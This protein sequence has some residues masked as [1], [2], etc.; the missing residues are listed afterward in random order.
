MS[1]PNAIDFGRLAEAHKRLRAMPAPFEGGCFCGAFRYR[2]SKPPFWSSNCHCRA[3]QKLTG[4]SFSTA[5]TVKA[6]GFEVLSGEAFKFDRVAESEDV[7]TVTRCATCGVWVFAE[8]ASKPEYRSILA[9]TLDDASKFVLISDVFVTEA[10][11]WTVF[12]PA[13]TQFQKMP[14]DELPASAP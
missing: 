6:D 14:E 2:C 4:S 10:A 3:C 13:L 8:R 7:V 1:E 12:D 9:S 5:F 11:P